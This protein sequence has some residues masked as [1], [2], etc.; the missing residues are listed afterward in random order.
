MSPARAADIARTAQRIAIIGPS[1]A[2]KS[3]LAAAI[4]AARGLAVLHLDQIA[5]A[6]GSAW[7]RVDDARLSAAQDAFLAARDRWV[8]EGNYSACMPARLARADALIWCDPPLSGCLRRYALRCLVRDGGRSGGLP[9]ARREFSWGL[10]WH[11]LHH[12]PR[13]ARRY[14]ALASAYPRLT[15]LRLTRFRD[16]LALAEG[17]RSAGA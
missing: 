9:G 1:C 16:I 13:N 14:Q 12:Y 17:H 10:V 11:T 15:T 5:H 8:I 2:G 6:P 3:T 7:K 4:G